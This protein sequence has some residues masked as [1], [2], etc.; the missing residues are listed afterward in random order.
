M[1]IEDR[2]LNE[3][4]EWNVKWAASSIFTG[5]TDSVSLLLLH[6]NGEGLRVLHQPI[7]ALKSFVLAML[8]F[9]EVQKKAQDEIDRV[10]GTDRL[11]SLQDRDQLPYIRAVV[12]EL[13]R[14]AP[15]TPLGRTWPVFMR[16][17]Y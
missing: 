16:S 4:D 17:V 14:W 7:S 11:P 10:I 13:V 8:L 12:K 15:G 3:E 6:N 2:E 9:P 5:G 1:N